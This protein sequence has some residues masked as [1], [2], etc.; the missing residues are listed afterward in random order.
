MS[1]LNPDDLI[2]QL[3]V[4]AKQLQKTSVSRSEFL[5]VTGIREWHVLKHFDSWNSFV[6][7]AGLQP[8]DVRRIPNEELYRAMHDTF[9][10]EGGVVTQT[11]FRRICQYSA[12]VYSKRWGRWSN[13][14]LEFRRWVQINEPDFPYIA[15][16]PNGTVDHLLGNAELT[17]FKDAKATWV[18]KGG[19]QYGPIVNFRGL[20]HAPINEQGVVFLFGMVAHELGYVVESVGTG[21]PDCE[22]KR[23]ISR[24]A[25]TWERV[26]IEFEF[27]S[28]NFL[29]HGHNLNECDLIVCWEHDWPE[30]SIEVLELKSSIASLQR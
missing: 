11:R 18:P 21:F 1:D 13:V 6:Q 15:D 4:V 7:A 12:D 16:L 5:R 29:A 9:V 25:N 19:R 10:A 26:R 22:A 2:K 23:R 24:T 17:T 8:I 20:Q 14:L 30:C 27:R 3:Q 28:R